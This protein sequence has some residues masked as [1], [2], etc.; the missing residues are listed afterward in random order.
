[1]SATSLGQ[2]A[3]VSGESF[4]D[5]T[6]ELMVYLRIGMETGLL[7]GLLVVLALLLGTSSESLERNLVG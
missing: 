1:M 3:P 6:Q 2:G 4:I 7:H 5:D